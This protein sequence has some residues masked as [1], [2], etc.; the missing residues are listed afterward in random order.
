MIL[1]LIVLEFSFVYKRNLCV[2]V[3]AQVHASVCIHV[4][5]CGCAG[6]L[7]CTWRLDQESVLPIHSV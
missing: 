3:C 5:E 2:Y 4:Y 6:A 1:K 7:S